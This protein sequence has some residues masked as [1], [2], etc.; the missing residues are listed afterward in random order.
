[1][2][3]C[4]EGGQAGVA[5]HLVSHSH[6]NNIHRLCRSLLTRISLIFIRCLCIVLSLLPSF[7][8]T[9][10]SCMT[11]PTSPTPLSPFQASQSLSPISQSSQRTTRRPQHQTRPINRQLSTSQA[12]QHD[13]PHHKTG[14]QAGRHCNPARRSLQTPPTQ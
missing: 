14:S 7:S 6:P 2:S 4:R 13:P 5:S 3:C 12:S 9:H 11:R 10:P 1:V 8:Y